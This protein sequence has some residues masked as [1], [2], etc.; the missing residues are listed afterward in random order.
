MALKFDSNWQLSPIVDTLGVNTNDYAP[1]GLSGASIIWLTASASIQLTGLTGG[2]ERRIMFIGL[3]LASGA[4]E[5]TIPAESVSS[6]AANRFADAAL[7]SLNGTGSAHIVLAYIYLGS[8]WRRW[9][10]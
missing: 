10:F 5:I 4:N 6:V 2:E 7:L 9:K 1:A 8:R 3:R